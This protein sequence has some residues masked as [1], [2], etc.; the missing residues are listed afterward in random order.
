M[1]ADEAGNEGGGRGAKHLE[2][3]PFLLNQALDHYEGGQEKIKSGDW[4][5]YGVEQKALKRALDNLA[6]VL[7]KKL[8][9][10]KK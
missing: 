10:P 5:G 2:R 4:A 7:E 8:T 3:C 1:A 9:P 6:A